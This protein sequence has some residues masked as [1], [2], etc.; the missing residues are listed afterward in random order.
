[1]RVEQGAAPARAED[2]LLAL[3]GTRWTA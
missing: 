2:G 1:M 3:D